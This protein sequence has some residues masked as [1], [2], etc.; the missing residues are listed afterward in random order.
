M[1]PFPAYNKRPFRVRNAE[2]LPEHSLLDMFVLPTGGTIDPFGFDNLI[3][4]GRMG[5]GKTM[6][7]RANLLL[8]RYLMVEKVISGETPIF[9]V[10][11]RLSDFQHLSDPIRIYS[12]VIIKIV[13]EISLSYR[14]FENARTLGSLHRG[15]SFLK[16]A[17]SHSALSAI[18][19]DL[20]KLSAEEFVTKVRSA[21]GKS[22]ALKT[23]FLEV[24]SHFEREVFLEIKNTPN[25]GIVD[26]E[27]AYKALLEPLGGSIL[28]LIDEASALSNRFFRGDA[29]ETSLF[30][31][32]M[33]QLRTAPY[34]RV[35]FAVYP[36]SYSDILTETRYGDFLNLS[37]DVADLHGY[38]QFRGRV[39]ELIDRYIAASTGEQHG[40]ASYFEACTDF[41][42]GIEQL[43][44]GS[45]G[46]MRRMVLLLDKAF[47][48]ANSETGGRGQVTLKHATDAL[49]EHAKGMEEQHSPE[50]KKFLTALASACKDRTAYRFV[51]PYKAPI[52]SKYVSRSEEQNVLSIVEAGSGQR[53]TQYAFDYSYCVYK[54][55]PTHFQKDSERIQ[56]SRSLG[57]GRWITK[58]A[59]I[60]EE[61]LN[62]VEMIKL[63]GKIVHYALSHEYGMILSNDGG[64]YY[65]DRNVFLTDHDLKM[66]KVGKRV[67]FSPVMLSKVSVAHQ[68]EVLD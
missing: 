64:T 2:E 65:F 43:I 30:E 12:A 41:G 3:I 68:L 50:E 67:K 56:P 23:Q 28:L 32:L 8:Y 11:I 21:D 53:G 59:T 49:I 61:F 29:G 55:I 20:I 57:D 48:I 42:C 19:D 7:L 10:F 13:E 54:G 38:T 36:N 26:I 15:V 18:S 39:I 4:K 60:R 45:G 6:V 9:P 44:Y 34:L 5:S 27:R 52:L 35:K 46:N 40:S 22:G 17:Y 24:A 14:V 16:G 1:N 31:T 33:N 58:K 37:E 25:P 47:Q 62:Q 63:E 51:F 66:A